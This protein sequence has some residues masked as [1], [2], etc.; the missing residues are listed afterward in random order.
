MTWLVDGQEI[1]T[2]T[3]AQYEAAG[4]SWEPFSGEWPVYLILN[5]A[6]GNEWAGNEIGTLPAQMEVDWY[7]RTA[8]D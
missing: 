8:Y 1:G 3:Q 6:V 4:G 5:V 2:V 7:G